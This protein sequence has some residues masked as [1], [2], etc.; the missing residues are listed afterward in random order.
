VTWREASPADDDAI[1]AW[2]AALNHEDPGPRPVPEA[3][4]RATLATFRREP[5]RG[6][7]AVLVVDGV[8]AGYA[9]LVSFWSNELGG[10]VCTVDE[11]YV[12]PAHRGRGYAAALL[13]A[14]AAG[15]GPWP[16]APVAMELE[17]SPANVR[18]R[19]LYERLGFRAIRNA[20][21][22]WQP[23]APGP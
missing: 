18:A 9:F 15:D 11:L 1:V 16:R 17:V 14:L 20:T 22:R 3:H 13:R 23:A 19:A 2:C 4:A 6:R 5:V 7:A 12:A 21:M 8:T 10:E